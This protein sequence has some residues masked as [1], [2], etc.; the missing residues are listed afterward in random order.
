VLT[1]T[2]GAEAKSLFSKRFRSCYGWAFFKPKNL[3][4]E[5]QIEA[6]SSSFQGFVLARYSR[7]WRPKSL[8][9]SHDDR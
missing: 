9:Y 8:P 7:F 4:F 2:E 6:F 1:I 3:G 5:D